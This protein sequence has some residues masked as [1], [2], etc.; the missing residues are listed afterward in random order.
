MCLYKKPKLSTIMLHDVCLDK[1]ARCTGQSITEHYVYV[2]DPVCTWPWPWNKFPK[3][4][5]WIRENDWWQGF[6]WVTR[7]GWSRWRSVS[8]VSR[9]F[10][11]IRVTKSWEAVYSHQILALRRLIRR[12]L[13]RT[14]TMI[15]LYSWAERLTKHRSNVDKW[16]MYLF[17]ELLRLKCLDPPN[18]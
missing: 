1:L 7:C 3:I 4:E 11:G 14:T 9:G 15:N 13:V 16:I 5:S 2:L 17:E 6:A 8:K 10:V 18:F 12:I